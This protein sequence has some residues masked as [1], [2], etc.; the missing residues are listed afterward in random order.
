MTYILPP[1]LYNLNNID[2]Y[3][4]IDVNSNFLYITEKFLIDIVDANCSSITKGDNNK[5]KEIE[6]KE[7][8][9]TLD[10]NLIKIIF[11]ID[12]NIDIFP[13]QGIRKACLIRSGVQFLIDYLLHKKEYKKIK[14]FLINEIDLDEFDDRLKKFINSIE[15]RSNIQP[16]NLFGLPL[17]H[18]WWY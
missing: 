16:I 18:W 4:K 17:S 1:S 9:D 5:Q 15:Y 10:N 6:E 3:S 7:E 8:K 13:K 14:D 11:C 2:F 12:L